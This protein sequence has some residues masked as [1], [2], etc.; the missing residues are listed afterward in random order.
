MKKEDLMKQCRYYL[1]EESCPYQADDTVTRQMA[2]FWDM[3]RVFVAS[4]GS[5]DGEAEYYK[6]IKGKSYK[7]IPDA[8]LMVMFTSWCKTAYDVQNEIGNFYQI[9]D[10]YLAT[11]SDH[12]PTDQIPH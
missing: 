9:V 7:G 5:F 2:W 1:G 4:G 10:D 12:F 3:E 8:L 6:R 11:A